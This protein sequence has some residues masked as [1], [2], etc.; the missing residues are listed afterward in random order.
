MNGSEARAPKVFVSYSWD[1]EEHRDW[2]NSFAARL[3]ADGVDA[4]LDQWDVHLGDPLPEFMEG[5]V[6]ENDFVL[7]ICTP[8]YKER[9]D[10]RVGGVGY[11]GDIMTAEVFST[12]DHRKFIPL[13]RRGGWSSALPSW[14]RG[15]AGVD[16]RCNPYSEG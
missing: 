2:V 11:E 10:R 14:L 3:R 16:L 13:L 15:K 1:D 7:V 4:K 5:A 8:K 12:R 9:S 6:R